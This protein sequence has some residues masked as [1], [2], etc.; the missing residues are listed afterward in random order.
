MSSSSH[1][2][3]LTMIWLEGFNCFNQSH[4]TSWGLV[5]GI[6]MLISDFK[7]EITHLLNNTM[8]GFQTLS[9]GSLSTLMPP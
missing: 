5:G 6:E 9:G 4:F 3:T 1:A 7:R 8:S 2:D